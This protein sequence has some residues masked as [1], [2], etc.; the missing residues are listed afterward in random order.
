PPRRDVV[1]GHA[2]RGSGAPTA[3]PCERPA[4]LEGDIGF[5]AAGLESVAVAANARFRVFA[6]RVVVTEAAAHREA[7]QRPL[8][9]R[10]ETAVGHPVIDS[11]RARIDFDSRR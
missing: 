7:L 10:V 5:V 11:G 3:L 6:G 9:L 4:N 8:I 2:L 1:I